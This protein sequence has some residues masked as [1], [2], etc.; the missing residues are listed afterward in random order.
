[1]KILILTVGGSCEP[2]VTS[3]RTHQPDIV[4]FICSDDT[5]TAKGSYRM[6][7][8]D[9]KVCGKDPKHPDLP[10]VLIQ[11]QRTLSERDKIIRIRALDDLNACY[12]R[13]YEI[14]R[15]LRLRYPDAQII[16][17]YTGGTKTM[18]V[19]LGAAA[20]DVPNI[21]IGI[22]SGQRTDLIK[23]SDG[24]QT[25]RFTAAGSAITKRLET[26][27]DKF[28]QRFDYASAS[29]VV[30][31]MIQHSSDGS[32]LDLFQRQLTALR[33]F[34]AWDRFDHDEA[35]RLLT[36]IRKW[37]VPYVRFL[38]K[39]VAARKNIEEAKK[40]PSESNSVMG[41]ELLE[42]LFLNIERRVK[43]ERYDDAVGRLYRAFEL[44]AQLIL[45]F[46][47]GQDTGNLNLGHLPE[48]LR[49]KYE[50]FR[51]KSGKIEISLVQSFE[52]LA[53]LGDKAGKLF[54]DQRSKLLNELQVRNNSI[55]AHG[56]K[57]IDKHR[58]DSMNKTIGSFI[59]D[60]VKSLSGGYDAQ[61]QLPNSLQQLD[62]L[63]V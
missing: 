11:V 61:Y 35:L 42:D 33:A 50:M 14:L 41:T 55:L 36:P 2:I 37:Y 62:T 17:D 16:A 6:V 9:G 39:I 31:E 57:P 24:T 32:T 58:F 5:D 63:N 53:E 8:G 56:Y 44:T 3:L 40:S 1:M 34:D 12:Q 13:S 43:Q 28:L 15:S 48:T 19:G 7:N 51:S 25:V 46:R 60:A 23:V 54:E 47:Y 29:H 4:Y 49:G 22:V 18:S 27:L 21:N 26:I 52:L 45:L 59:R 20:M 38:E 30:E 10:N